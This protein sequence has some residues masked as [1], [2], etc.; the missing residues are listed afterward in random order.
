MGYCTEGVGQLAGNVPGETRSK[1]VEPYY[2]LSRRIC[3]R[4]VSL[5]IFEKQREKSRLSNG[6]FKVILLLYVRHL[7]KSQYVERWFYHLSSNYAQMLNVTFS[8]LLYFSFWTSWLK[9]Y[10]SSNLKLED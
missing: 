5:E 9:Q 2:G 8:F 3:L 4:Y 1:M 10:S 6:H 7:R